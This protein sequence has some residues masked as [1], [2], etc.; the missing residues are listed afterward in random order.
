VLL[1]DDYDY[2]NESTNGS[3]VIPASS[4]HQRAGGDGF[5]FRLLDMCWL[6]VR[7]RW[8]ICNPTAW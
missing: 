6:A 7:L 4:L 1:V 2:A 8:L 3:A 5:R